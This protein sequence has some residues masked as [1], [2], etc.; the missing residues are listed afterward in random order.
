MLNEHQ[1]QIEF[2]KFI[3]DGREKQ[4]LYQSNVAEMLGISQ[5][6]YSQ[7][8]NGARNVDLVLSLKICEVLHLN[9]TDFVK[10]YDAETP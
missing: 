6:Y 9:I 8:E 4:K 5:Q 7:I 1:C 2:G 10:I 3:K